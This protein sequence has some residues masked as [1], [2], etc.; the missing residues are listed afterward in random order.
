MDGILLVVRQNYC[1][2][3]ALSDAVSQFKFVESR[4]LGVVLNCTSD[5]SARY[6]KRYYK[7]YRRYYNRYQGSYASRAKTEKDQ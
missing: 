2:R 7:G 5:E 3:N 6:G 1:D 4:I